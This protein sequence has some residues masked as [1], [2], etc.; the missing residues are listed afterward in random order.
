LADARPSGGAAAII[1]VSAEATPLKRTDS[2]LFTARW[3]EDAAFGNTVCC[4]AWP[5][6]L[7]DGSAF[8]ADSYL[9]ET[10]TSLAGLR[11]RAAALRCDRALEA[12]LR[13]LER[14][15]QPYFLD[16]PV[17]IAIVLC[18]RRPF[19]LIGSSSDIELL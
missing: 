11:Q 7:P 4:V 13:S 16:A 14:C 18:A 19:H 5:D 17:P 15:F 8:V 12:F 1:E 2:D 9:P 3:A 10:V 6:K